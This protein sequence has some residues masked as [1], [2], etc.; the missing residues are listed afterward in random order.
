MKRANQYN[1]KHNEFAPP[2]PPRDPRPPPQLI[3]SERKHDQGK[4]KKPLIG[5]NDKAT[6]SN[7]LSEYLEPDS[8]KE[9]VNRD[10]VTISALATKYLDEDNRMEHPISLL[11]S[12]ERK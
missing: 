11:A 10:S 1:I 5:K 9:V 12:L 3:K 4:Q 6:I 7:L 2:I 8:T